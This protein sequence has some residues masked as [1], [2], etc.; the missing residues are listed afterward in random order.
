MS[1][2]DMETEPQPLT[3]VTFECNGEIVV[4]S[5]PPAT[6]MLDMLRGSEKVTSARA[7]CRIGRCGACNVLLD[8]K[9]IP[10]CLVMAWQMPGRRVET[11]EGLAGDPDF[12]AVKEALAAESAVQCGYCIPGFVVSLIAGLRQRRRGSNVDLAE[13]VA[14]NLCRCTGYGGLRRALGRLGL[15]P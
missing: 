4:H 2:Q 7:G 5:V 13:A 11:L 3:S 14:G 6:T 1:K 10:A 9:A 12:L 8:D 15:A